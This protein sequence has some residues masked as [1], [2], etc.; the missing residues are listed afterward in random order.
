MNTFYIRKNNCET[1]EIDD[2]LMI[3][4]PDDFTV[5][6]LNGAG[7][8]CWA[9]LEKRQSADMLVQTLLDSGKHAADEVQTEFVRLQ[10]DVE[11][12]LTQMVAYGLLEHAG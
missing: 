8:K 12:F 7:G 4:N 5:T 10:A 9:L 6:N 11:A 1:V 2:H 3:V